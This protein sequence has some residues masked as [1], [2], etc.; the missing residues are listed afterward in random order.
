MWGTVRMIAWKGLLR[1]KRMSEERRERDSLTGGR[2]VDPRIEKCLV[3]T[4][5]VTLGRNKFSK[6]GDR[7]EV[8]RI[9]AMRGTRLKIVKGRGKKKGLRGERRN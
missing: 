4:E 3:G 1:Q 6:N 7:V 5:I 2:E 8:T 9:K